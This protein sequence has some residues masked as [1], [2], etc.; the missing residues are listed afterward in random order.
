MIKW[1]EWKGD[2]KVKI[3]EAITQRSKSTTN[4]WLQVLQNNKLTSINYNNFFFSQMNYHYYHFFF[5]I[6][7]DSFLK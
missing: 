7:N 2:T 1:I 6:L 3:N 4:L 5:C